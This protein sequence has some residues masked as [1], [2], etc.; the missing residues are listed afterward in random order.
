MLDDIPGC[1]TL[2]PGPIWGGE[3][4]LI[5]RLQTKSLC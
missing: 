1:Q 4:I 3:S 2:L 5:N